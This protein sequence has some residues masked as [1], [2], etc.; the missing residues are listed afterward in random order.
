MKRRK[1]VN[2]DLFTLSVLTT[3]TV[4]TW[5]GFDVYRT[6]NKSTPK[7]VEKALLQ[8]LDPTFDKK[9]IEFLKTRKYVSQEELDS[10]PELTN[11]ELQTKTVINLQEF[12]AT[13]SGTTE[14]SPSANTNL[15]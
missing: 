14:S 1:T 12:I 3:I 6:L 4:F 5:I 11:L 8:K 15:E 2:K 10:I 9:T 7:K 13:P